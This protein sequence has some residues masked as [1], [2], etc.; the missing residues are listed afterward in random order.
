MNYMGQPYPGMYGNGY[1]NGINSM[2]PSPT[3]VQYPYGKQEV[4]TVHGETGVDK[5][6]LHTPNSSVLLLDETAPI[7]WLVTTDGTGYPTKT[8][9][10]ISP[11]KSQTEVEK[12]KVDKS[13]A[14]LEERISRLENERERVENGKS[15]T[16]P[17]K[18]HGNY[19]NNSNGNNGNQQHNSSSTNATN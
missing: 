5:F 10:D 1:N 8:P 14:S 2:L 7:V 16:Q 17:V 12:E 13:F 11:H 19:S 18:Q 9:Y 15:Y 4:I 6:E 3:P